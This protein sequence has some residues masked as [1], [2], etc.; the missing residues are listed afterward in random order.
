MEH[1]LTDLR[2]AVRALRKSPAFAL[3]A[4]LCI[5]IGIGLNTTIFSIVDAALLRPF[6]FVEPERLVVVD[7]VNL[8]IGEPEGEFSIP[9]LADLRAQTRSFTDVAAYTWRSATITGGEEPERVPGLLVTWN[10]FPLIGER[11]ALGRAFRPDDDRP[12]AAPVVLIS[13]D[14]WRRRFDGDSGAVGAAMVV[15]GVPRTIV[16]V[17]RPG[18]RFFENEHL[19]IPL[20]ADPARARRTDRS[21]ET[22]AR[23]GPGVDIEAARRDVAAIGARVA[24]AHPATNEGWEWRVRPI[25]DDMTGDQT[26]LIVSTMMGAVGLVLLVACA[27]VANLL[28]ARATARERE[29]AVRTALGASRGRI[30]RQLL[31]ESVVVALAG[32]LLGAALAVWGVQLV[33]AAF[34]PGDL[35][36]FVQFRIDAR[37]LGF[38]LALAVGT[39]LL[40]GLAPAL[41]TTRVSLVG[42]LKEGG[43]GASGGRQRLR[44]ALVVGEVALSLVLLVGA[45]LFVRSF[46]NLQR[47]SPGF[48]TAHLLALRVF[49]PGTRYDEPAARVRQVD[50]LVRRIEGLPG[51]TSAAASNLVP[52]DGGG[53]HLPIELDGRPTTERERPMAR[54]SGVTAHFFRTLDVPVLAGRMLDGREA[55]DGAPVAVVNE[56][57]VRRHWPEG[58]PL[59][60]RVRAWLDDSTAVS[61]TT[62]GVVRDINHD[63]MD[64]GAEAAIYAPFAY[65]PTRNAGITI[66]TTAADPAS[67]AAPVRREIR[68][69]SPDLPVFAVHTMEELRYLSFWEYGLFG[70]MFSTFGG[71]ALLLAVVGVYGVMSYAVGQRTREIGVRVAL[72]AREAD[73]LRLVVTQGA[74]L[75]LAGIGIG[76][77]GAFAAARVIASIL[78]DTSPSDP[79]SY[80]GI[81]VLLAAAALLACA[82]PAR[83]AARV[84]PVEALRAE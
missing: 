13:D 79:L 58:D 6:P 4:V 76:L 34:P 84:D 26:A 61:L 39:G 24:A 30:V 9:D 66:R 57:F 38:T 11:P 37:A 36:W 71:I 20:A 1:L 59:G 64:E 27:N 2:L 63:G 3:V 72:G 73:V 41:Q 53:D 29:I 68:A 70:A 31:T 81:A 50:E 56:S 14:L 15:D 8:A 19:W 35:P 22:W 45:S 32:G 21:L 47:A 16:G 69:A 67:L 60:R 7:E 10:L 74:R 5:G 28:L 75:A 12:G 65:Q 17:M 52:I 82:L 83:R 25:R 49:L 55:A 48:D 43:R 77:V 42:A 40:F 23:L 33:L 80:A 18:F 78:Y 46:M 62:I 54:F 44:S 51:V